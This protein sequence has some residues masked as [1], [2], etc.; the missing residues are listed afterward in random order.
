VPTPSPRI[1]TWLGIPHGST[2][3][4]SVQG[5]T[6]TELVVASAFVLQDD[7]HRTTHADA[8]IQ[9]GPL[10]LAFESPRK[11]SI[12]IDLVFG[13]DA[14]AAV[15]AEVLTPTGEA[16]PPLFASSIAGSRGD[17]LSVRLFVTT[18]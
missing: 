6:Q 3:Q 7:G 15:A 1:E 10:Q 4:V 9:P 14:T 18:L 13:T 16:L 5:T 8:E 11:Y 2:M 17:A 12:E